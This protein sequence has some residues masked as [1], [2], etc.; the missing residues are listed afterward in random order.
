M[1]Q[2]VNDGPGRATRTGEDG[3][4]P[5]RQPDWWRGAVIYQ[6]YPRSFRDS[7]G[8][9][10]GDLPGIAEKLDHLA[11]LGVDAI[12]ICPFYR[13]PMQDFG[14]DVSDHCDVDPIFGTLEDFDRLLA[15]A[16][17]RGLRVLVDL[18]LSHTSDRH[19]WFLESRRDR[20][21]A[22]ADWYVWADA[23]ADGT[24]PNN[25][26][27]VFGG[28]AWS[29]EPRRRQYYLHNFLTAQPDL[30]F[31]NPRVQEA[32]LDIAGFWLERGVDGF[33]LDASNAYFHDAELRDNPAL[34]PGEAPVVGAVASG[35]PYG[36]QRHLHNMNRPEVIAFLR[37][38]RALLDRHPGT[39]SIAEIASDES[40]STL[41]DYTRGGD[42]LH[43][44]YTFDL[45]SG[46]FSARRI[47][48]V[49]EELESRIADG[50]PCWAFGNHDVA[51]ALTRWGGP[52][53]GD[54]FARLLMALLL[55]LRGSVCIYQGE[56][57][58]LP[59][60]A[61]AC[62]EL[63]DPY[64]KAFWPDIA[65]RDGC[66][67]P[68]PW[69][70][71]APQGGFSAGDP[72]LPIPEAHLARSVAQQEARPDSL[73]NAYR[74]FLAWRRRHPALRHGDIAFLETEA[75]LLAFKRRGGGE[76]L[77]AVFNLGPTPAVLSLADR[78]GLHPL[79]D[80]GLAGG[81]V[82]GV[83]QLPGYGVFFGS[84]DPVAHPSSAAGGSPD[85]VALG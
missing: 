60:A 74:S 56:E 39:A 14:Y 21:N 4:G 20:T 62:E 50:W 3:G 67:T 78:A 8:D 85:E 47:R 25:W 7:N 46:E 71:A 76:H 26:L 27:S 13:S 31:H 44:G 33:R 28:G 42:R 63:R 43:M 58:G 17:D 22:R 51:R 29:W 64:G 5:D 24:P 52:Q 2:W 83:V 10:I 36:R 6:I 73:L 59:E 35:N 37:R 34:A 11:G 41:A 19:P 81:L 12:W 68:M 80:H 79:E 15:A 9:G 77:V 66:R 32:A 48:Q 53:A 69:T 38:L 55:S 23:K 16:H 18:V 1:P 84:L 70:D 72:W 57:L 65:G 40:L 82:E 54:D 30:N 49:I 45:L 61:L 75:P